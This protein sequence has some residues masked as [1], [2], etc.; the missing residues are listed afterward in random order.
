LVG[1]GFYGG[2][3]CSDFG[4]GGRGQLSDECV[5]GAGPG[6]VNRTGLLPVAG[7]V[8]Q[9]AVVEGGGSFTGFDDVEEADITRGSG[10]AITSA[11]P[12]VATSSPS[13]TSPAR[14]R[15][16]VLYEMCISVEI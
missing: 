4:E 8:A 12:W 9:H 3:G 16:K 5:L 11:G 10:Q 14:I 13:A 1:A 2:V 6:V 7:A 15:V